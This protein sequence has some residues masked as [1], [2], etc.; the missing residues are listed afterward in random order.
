[1]IKFEKHEFSRD[2]S[3]VTFLLP[4]TLSSLYPPTNPN[5]AS[6]SLSDTLSTGNGAQL[7]LKPSI[8][9]Y[10]PEITV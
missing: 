3:R 10:F 2:L 7:K 6:V 5:T 9:T 8:I 4:L 1:M